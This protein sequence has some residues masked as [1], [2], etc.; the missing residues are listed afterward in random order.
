MKILF[1]FFSQPPSDDWRIYDFVECLR[2]SF[3]F[4]SRYVGFSLIQLKS[5][6]IIVNQRFDSLEFLQTN[7]PCSSYRVFSFVWRNRIWTNNVDFHWLRAEE[8]RAENI[9]F[10]S[11]S[12]STGQKMSE[13]L[14]NRLELSI[15]KWLN[16]GGICS[17]HLEPFQRSLYP[18]NRKR[19]KSIEA[20]S[21]TDIFRMCDDFLREN[22]QFL[23]LSKS[24]EVKKWRNT[25]DATL[26][27]D[28]KILFFLLLRRQWKMRKKNDFSFENAL[29]D[30]IL[31][32]HDNVYLVLFEVERM[33][34]R[35][36]TSPLE[37][38]PRQS[39]VIRREK[40]VKHT[41]FSWS[42]QE[43]NFSFGFRFSFSRRFSTDDR[44]IEITT[45]TI[46]RREQM[47]SWHSWVQ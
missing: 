11:F 24:L 4:F 35:M 7:R 40:F 25:D 45:L 44:I 19:E 41:I 16:R 33:N 39:K 36:L 3:S 46:P 28:G 10:C 30:A 42:Q 18:T 47:R 29:T 5:L 13:E 23:N 37:S 20:Q 9:F 14:A 2:Y 38:Y 12:F 17:T 27:C 8:K 26:L 31:F 43:T 22:S 15:R 6:K 32:D 21:T 1:F 34:S